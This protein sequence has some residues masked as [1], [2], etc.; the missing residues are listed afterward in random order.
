MPSSDINNHKRNLGF[1]LKNLRKMHRFSLENI[2]RTSAL[3]GH[4]ISVS[5]LSKIESGR[6]FPS[7]PILL[8][9]SKIYDVKPK[10]LIEKLEL[11]NATPSEGS[12]NV[13]DELKFSKFPHL[14]P[15][16]IKKGLSLV[17]P[18]AKLFHFNG[19][20]DAHLN[21]LHAVIFLRKTGKLDTAKEAAEQLIQM[22]TKYKERHS[23][24]YFELAFIY[25]MQNKFP[26]AL[27]AI[28][29]AERMSRSAK[30]SWLIPFILHLKGN[31][32][33]YLERY[34]E[35]L[36]AY[37]STVKAFQKKNYEIDLCRLLICIGS[38]YDH[39][40]IFNTARSYYEKALV[41]AKKQNYLRSIA[42][43]YSNIGQSFY[44]ENKFHVAISFLNESNKIA[45]A[46]DNQ[47]ITFSNYYCL[48]KV[49]EKLK[50]DKSKELC[51][52]SLKYYY[53]KVGDIP[54]N[55]KEMEKYIDQKLR[56]FQT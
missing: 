36:S 30:E 50:D 41:I 20:K 6:A 39:L 43:A 37:K 26:L 12:A 1:Y 46:S 53:S 49:Y 51:E 52:K 33:Y 10:V 47:D 35:A 8:L 42:L 48:M 3:H 56:T 27:T 45:E 11:D 31:I 54:L 2:E 19:R 44:D 23:R 32:L 16:R 25:K 22:T 29:E 40:K 21:L 24:G 9:L 4:K 34:K 28:S 14:D 17:R 13:Y 38:A 7:I 55:N 15:E 5:H 18:S